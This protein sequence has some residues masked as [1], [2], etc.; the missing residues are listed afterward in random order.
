MWEDWRMCAPV[1]SAAVEFHSQNERYHDWVEHRVGSARI[2]NGLCSLSTLD[3]ALVL[4]DFENLISEWLW[5]EVPLV[6]GWRIR[7]F[8]F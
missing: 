5:Q 4:P 1:L 7:P 3:R 6:T 2:S 8:L